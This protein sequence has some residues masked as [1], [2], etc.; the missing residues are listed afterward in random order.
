M[1]PDLKSPLLKVKSMVALVRGLNSNSEPHG[2]AGDPLG[3]LIPEAASHW[4]PPQV[5]CGKRP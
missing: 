1:P 2:V 4:T 5:R 3:H